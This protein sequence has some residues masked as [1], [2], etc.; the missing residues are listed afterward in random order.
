MIVSLGSHEMPGTHMHDMRWTNVARY[1]YGNSLIHIGNFHKSP[2]LS[3]PKFTGSLEMP[4][5]IMEK[6]L[7]TWNSGDPP[8]RFM[9]A[10]DSHEMD[11]MWWD[12]YM[13]SSESPIHEFPPNSLAL[14]RCQVWQWE[15][16]WTDDFVRSTH[17]IDGSWWFSWDGRMWWNEIPLS[18]LSHEM[19]GELSMRWHEVDEMMTGEPLSNT[20]VEALFC[21]SSKWTRQDQGQK[22]RWVK[23]RTLFIACMTS[24]A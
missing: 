7:T 4:S 2:L 14:W 1:D 12:Q 15:K 21:I 18:R 16:S 17:E 9:W 11:E 8:M 20:W 6:I 13:G 24:L 3:F 5:M 23:V 22:C 19:P 10:G